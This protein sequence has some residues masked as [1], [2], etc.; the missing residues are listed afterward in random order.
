MLK[1]FMHGVP[2][3]Y[4]GPRKAELL[5]RYLKKFVAP[6]VAMLGSDAAVTEFVEE[7]GTFF[8]IFIGFRL[9]ESII[10][11]LAIKY[12]K[13]AWFAVAKYFSE[14]AMVLYFDKVPAFVAIQPAYDERNIF[15]GPFEG[16]FV[17]KLSILV[18]MVNFL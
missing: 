6:N 5:I 3:E 16:Q 4:Y 14:D 2:T 15:Y 11:N 17:F 10:T 12:K 7:A 8:P 18:C 9:D 1:I 13:K